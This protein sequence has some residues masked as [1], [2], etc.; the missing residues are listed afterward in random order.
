M[1]DIQKK[2]N[3][4]FEVIEGICDEEHFLEKSDKQLYKHYL[5]ERTTRIQ[6]K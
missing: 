1:E 2:Y 5:V 3:H 4:M 6:K